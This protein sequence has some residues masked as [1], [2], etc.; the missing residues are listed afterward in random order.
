M[1]VV[2]DS[3]AAEE[4]KS[5]PCV[6]KRRGR[7]EQSCNWMDC[8]NSR[9]TRIVDMPTVYTSGTAED[10]GEPAVAQRNRMGCC[11]ANIDAR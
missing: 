7:C 4:L 11:Y 9:A 8:A 10:R 3:T 6:V 2:D 1:A 5:S